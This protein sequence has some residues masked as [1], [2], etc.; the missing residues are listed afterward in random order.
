MNVLYCHEDVEDRYRG[1]FMAFLRVAL[2]F[3]TIQTIL[4]NDPGEQVCL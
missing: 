4:Q 1:W 3:T 2:V